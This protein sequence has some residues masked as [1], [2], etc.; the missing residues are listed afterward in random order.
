MNAN[1]SF[2][3]PTSIQWQD[4][5]LSILNQQELPHKEDYLEL[6]EI[7]DVF[8][9]ILT[10]KVR[11]APAIGIAG[12]FG[13]AM[14][15]SKY[16]TDELGVFFNQLAKDKEYLLS[17]RPTAVNLSWALERLYQ[18]ALQSSSVNEAKTELQHEAIKIQ[19]EDEDMCR[20]IGENALTLL[21]PSHPVMTICNAGSIA[22]AKYGT[23]LAPF[24]IAMEKG[25]Q[26]KVYACETRPLL[27][28][29]RLTVWELLKSG[30][31]ATLIADSMAAYTIQE[32][33]IKAII[34]GADRIAQNGDTANKIGTYGLALLAQAFQ[35]PLYVA[36]PSSTFDLSIE[37]GREIPIEERKSEE[38]THFNGIPSAP[39][40]ARVFNPAF[41]VTPGHLI[42]A[43]ITENGILKPDYKD[44]I[45][46]LFSEQQ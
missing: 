33:N 19:A 23:A 4:N 39:L 15:A 22:T 38:I 42:T 11:G 7:E 21:D 30:V 6:L 3:I 17:S 12:A 35:I 2:H 26:F 18:L 37:T 34:V 31:D 32:K 8:E 25:K 41:D 1:T 45:S 13:L 16:E 5:R 20:K 28:G 44:S 27:Q 46:N 9:A 24:H 29:A 10:L 36:A 14:A 40:D 43:I